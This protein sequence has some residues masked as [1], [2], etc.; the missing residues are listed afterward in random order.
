MATT[1]EAPHQ[2]RCDAALRLSF[3]S[4]LLSKEAEDSGGYTSVKSPSDAMLEER[5]DTLSDGLPFESGALRRGGVPQLL[6]REFVGLLVQYGGVG[7]LYGALPAML[8]PLIQIYLKAS[9]AQ[10]LTAS[11]LVALPWSFKIFFGMLSDCLPIFGF[12][13]RPYMALGWTFCTIML[14]YMA[15]MPQENGN[16]LVDKYTMLMFFVTLGYM[17]TDVAADGLMVDLAQREAIALRGRTQSVIYA[18]RTGMVF[19]GEA[20][21]AFLFNGKEYGGSFDFSLDLQEFTV[22]LACCSAFVLPMTWFF[23]QEERQPKIRVR[24]HL[25]RL[26][27]LLQRRAVYQVIAYNF[28]VGIFS[29][30][31]MTAT[32]PIQKFLV[33]ATPLQNALGDVGANLAF[34]LAILGTSRWG[35]QCNWRAIALTT[36]AATVFVDGV[37][38]LFVIWDICRASVFWFGIPAAMHFVTGVGW[39]VNTFVVVEL[40]DLGTEGTIYAL[41]TTVHN[42]ASPFAVSLTRIIDAPFD[43]TNE[44]IQKDDNSIRVDLTSAAL[45]M[46]MSTMFSWSLIFLLPQQKHQTQQLIRLGGSSKLLGGITIGYLA[47]AMV[48]SIVINL[49]AIYPTTSCLVI[50]G[51]SGCSDRRDPLQ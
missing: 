14:V 2:A 47:L 31:T 39:V 27:R 24:G 49:M 16:G 1:N 48:W 33:H 46:C 30:I 7:L 23:V 21:V 32:S 50:T 29:G 19:I 28:F 36:G 17:L 51:G 9:G 34:T 3:S 20:L 15:C 26:W 12:R 25:R 10:Y 45:I 44:R 11:T 8:Y 5:S 37:V 18:V 43:L 4:L 13:R 42:L 41:I 35:L 22:L 40:A 38:V 6:S